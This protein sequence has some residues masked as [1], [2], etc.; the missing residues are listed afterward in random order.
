MTVT[1]LSHLARMSGAAWPVTES[2][3]AARWR[4]FLAVAVPFGHR[5]DKLMEPL[6]RLTIVSD[7]DIFRTWQLT[8]GLQL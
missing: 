4:E 8:I 7:T 1:T 2:A 3:G 6:G 5:L